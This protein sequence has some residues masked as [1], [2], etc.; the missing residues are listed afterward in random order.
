MLIVALFANSQKVE[1]TQVSTDRWMDKQMWYTHMMEYYSAL[2]SKEILV[3][4]TAWMNLEDTVLSER[5]QSLKDKYSMIK[6]IFCFVLFCFAFKG[7][8]CGIWKF[9]G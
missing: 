2:N 7:C 3:H 6:S 5:S 9:P 8:T 4:A 1:M